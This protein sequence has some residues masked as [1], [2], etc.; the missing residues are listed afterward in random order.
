M[1]KQLPQEI[2]EKIMNEIKSCSE[3]WDEYHRMFIDVDKVQKILLKHLSL[4]Q[5]QEEPISIKKATDYLREALHID[6]AID[7][8]D[9]WYNNWV[10]DCINMLKKYPSILEQEE[11]KMSE[12]WI[13][14]AI[15]Y[16]EWTNDN[17]YTTGRWPMTPK[18]KQ[19]FRNAVLKY[20]PE[21]PKLEQE[22][23]KQIE[24]VQVPKEIYDKMV[25]ECTLAAIR[26]WDFTPSPIDLWPTK[27]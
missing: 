22:D 7:N 14:Q 5:E 11:P 21:M 10:E 19:D 8:L 4:P 2:L 23:T 13:D 25:W 3:I 12:D 26:R 17:W 24:Y 27:R 6:Q 1:T 18:G 20:I 16:F 9:I 15:K